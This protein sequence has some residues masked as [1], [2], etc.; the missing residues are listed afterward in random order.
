MSVPKGDRGK[1]GVQFVDTADTIEQRAMEVCKKWP[2]SYVFIITQRTVALAS[3]VYEH[4]QKANAIMPQTEDERQER[5]LELERALGANYAFA[6]KI[7]RAF[8]LFPICGQ[9]DG[10]SQNEEAEKSGRLLEEFMTLCKD[11]EN[12][13]KGNLHYVRKMEL[14]KPPKQKG[15][16]GAAKTE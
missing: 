1:S 12:A 16:G 8:S 3:E 4:A 11:E 13:L 15:K 2:K 14:H 10:R 7:E 6:R 5:A 9:K